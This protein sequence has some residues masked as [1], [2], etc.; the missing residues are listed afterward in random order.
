M[1]PSKIDL[2]PELALKIEASRQSSVITAVS[3]ASQQQVVAV[4]DAGGIFLVDLEAV[5]ARSQSGDAEGIKA[6]PGVVD[7]SAIYDVAALQDSRVFVTAG[8]SPVAQLK[9]WDPRTSGSVGESVRGGSTMGGASAPPVALF[10][11]GSAG[12]VGYTSVVSHPTR[13]DIVA[14]GTSTGELVIWDIRQ[15]RS[16]VNRLQQHVPGTMVTDLRFDMHQALYSCGSD[17]A[18]LVGFSRVQGFWLS[19]HTTMPVRRRSAKRRSGKRHKEC[20]RP[21]TPMTFTLTEMQSPYPTTTVP[22]SG[23]TETCIESTTF[24]VDARACSYGNA[25]A[26][27]KLKAQ[28]CSLHRTTPQARKPP[29]SAALQTPLGVHRPVNREH[30]VSECSRVCSKALFPLTSTRLFFLVPA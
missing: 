1:C 12:N 29:T 3:V 24:G 20:R 8:A 14:A 5:Q 19:L 30:C 16:V 4:T 27:S 13:R 25:Y 15:T 26:I 21:P 7:N 17:R 22:C 18:A 10:S 6:K 11:D 9:V 28:R 2:V 23:A